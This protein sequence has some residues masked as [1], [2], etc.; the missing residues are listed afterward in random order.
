M[1]SHWASAGVRGT[2]F[3]WSTGDCAEK[4][5]YDKKQNKILVTPR[6]MIIS[7]RMA[8]FVSCFSDILHKPLCLERGIFIFFFRG[9]KVPITG[10]KH[11]LDKF[12]TLHSICKNSMKIYS[13]NENRALCTSRR[14][15]EHQLFR[16]FFNA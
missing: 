9:E 4:L 8:F 13:T 2:F 5:G 3:I 12:H 11:S 15:N 14:R 1:L 16:T 10:S 7:Y 6:R